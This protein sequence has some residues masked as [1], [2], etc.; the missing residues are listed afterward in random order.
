ME[1]MQDPVTIST[2]VTYERKNIEK[3][4]FSYKK[5]TCPTTMQSINNFEITPNHTLKRLILSW[6]NEEAARSRD[7]LKHDELV[8]MLAAMESTPFKVSSLRKLR[9]NIAESGHEVKDD[10]VKCGGIDILVQIIAQILVESLDFAAFTACEEALGILHICL[11][12]LS[13]DEKIIQF[14]SKPESIKSFAMMLQRGSAEARFHAVAIFRQL[15]RAD[16]NWKKF[17]TQDQG[18]EFFRS[19]L[20][21]VSDDQICSKASASALELLTDI[22]G[23]SKRSR[24]KAV[25]AGAVC[26]LIELLPDSSRSKCEKMLL[27]LKLLCECAEG[28]QAL[29]E[30]GLGVAAISKKLLHVSSAATKITVKILWLICFYHPSERVLE[31]MLIYGSV[32]KLFALLHVD[33]RS[34]TKEKVVKIFKLHANS[35]RQYPCFPCELK[36]YLGSTN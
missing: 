21:L 1:L 4:F 6:Q 22:L 14:L 18:F 12:S 35:W 17:V 30:H 16:Y 13:D 5:K 32:N 8:S 28:R 3:W 29:V 36:D 26:I 11:I 20:E 33:N 19:L 27:L 23:T 2:G 9:T 24:L 7:S 25:E 10:F 31:E 15:A 34:S